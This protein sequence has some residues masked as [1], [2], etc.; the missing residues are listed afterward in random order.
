MYEQR[1][2]TQHNSAMD[3]G[4][5][6]LGATTN[7]M[8]NQLQSANLGM[9]WGVRSLELGFMGSTWEGAP[10]GKLSSV[11]REEIVHLAKLNRVNLTIHGP[12]V[13]PAGFN[14]NSHVF[15]ESER[16][17][18]VKEFED[19]ITFA[20]QIGT[21]NKVDHIPVVM[22]GSNAAPGSPNPNEAMYFADRESG[23]VGVLQTRGNFVSKELISQY[24]P[25]DVVEK[26]FKPKEPG[27]DIGSLR[28]RAQIMLHEEQAKQQFGIELANMDYSLE[29]H[30][31]RL[32]RAQQSNNV[33]LIDSIKKE[34]EAL[35]FQKEMKK[36]EMKHF[37]QEYIHK[38][39]Q[40]YIPAEQM[41]V[42]KVAQTAAQLAEFSLEHTKSQPTIAI[43]NIYPNMALSRIDDLNK[44]IVLARETF[45]KNMTPKIGRDAAESA[46]EELIGSTVDIGHLNMWRK[47]KNPDTGDYYSKADI[48]QW[49]MDAR[50]YAKHVHLTDNF[51][52]V[53]AHLPVGWGNAPIKEVVD[54]YKK[55]GFTGDMILET[56]G[57]G[58][59]GSQMMVGI[60]ASFEQL[61]YE[62]SPTMNWTDA[63]S[64]YFMAG[65]AFT[66][67]QTL[68]DVSFRLYGAGFSGLPYSTGS[69]LPGSR[70]EETKFSG[71]PMS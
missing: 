57:V 38:D 41:A 49:A 37:E 64:S 46:S 6:G 55:E 18:S 11:E 1:F 47:Y 52:D 61:G 14:S 66:G 51:G 67:F 29:H 43:E 3:F 56:P 48:E 71:T 12:Y 60:P 45:I 30:Q 23:G 17:N 39:K 68:P 58:E 62:L 70:G 28:P 69:A 31:G 63:V 36:V 34:I 27:S 25:A 19:A 5:Y 59:K 7:H 21:A 15:D 24:L 54:R 9:N 50:K 16:L 2:E 53:D 26:E 32:E 65:Y 8:Q 13:D 33:E 35:F 10:L 22:H 42:E 4:P 20:D 40:R 44:T